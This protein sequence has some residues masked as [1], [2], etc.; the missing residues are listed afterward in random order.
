MIQSGQRRVVLLGTGE[1]AEIAFLTINELGLELAGVVDEPKQQDRFLGYAVQALDVVPTLDYD[2]I[3]VA[4]VHA[5]AE[6]LTRL[7]TLGIPTQRLIVPPIPGLQGLMGMRPTVGE[8]RAGGS[9][10][11]ESLPH[12]VRLAEPDVAVTPSG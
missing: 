1:L 12:E 9:K 5:S 8:P 2:R 11:Q 6:G 7:R 4:S 3:V 10:T